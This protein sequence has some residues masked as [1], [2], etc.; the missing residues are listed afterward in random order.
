MSYILFS[1][2]LAIS[3]VEFKTLLE[4]TLRNQL[5]AHMRQGQSEYI[6]THA[7]TY[8]PHGPGHKGSI[9]ELLDHSSNR[10]DSLD[11]MNAAGL[12]DSSYNND[13]F[14]LRILGSGRRLCWPG[15]CSS[16]NGWTIPP[17]KWWVRDIVGKPCFEV[18]LLETKTGEHV[19]GVDTK[20][21]EVYRVKNVLTPTLHKITFDLS[22]DACAD[23]DNTI[24]VTTGDA[25]AVEHIC[26]VSARASVEHMV[27]PLKCRR[28]YDSVD[29]SG[30]RVNV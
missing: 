8:V 2:L 13:G 16:K 23:E 28:T 1:Q 10:F 30:L 3:K 6:C 20:N 7:C 14:T 25:P 5:S 9:C 4:M 21:G 12:M 22:L 18:L 27:R 24:L 17:E 15:V 11:N 19:W 29:K 26:S